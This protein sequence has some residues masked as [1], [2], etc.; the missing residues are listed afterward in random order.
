MGMV[1]QSH[2]HVPEKYNCKSSLALWARHM[3]G[4]S[5]FQ[6]CGTEWWEHCPPFSITTHALCFALCSLISMNYKVSAASISAWEWRNTRSIIITVN[7]VPRPGNKATSL[8]TGCVRCSFFVSELLHVLILARG[9]EEI[10][11][12]VNHRT[13]YKLRHCRTIHNNGPRNANGF[14]V[15][16]GS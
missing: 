16:G 9:P 8:S 12:V 10:E 14:Y 5:L 7:L 2:E 1:E 13:P 6:A 15:P 4:E 3:K 11:Y